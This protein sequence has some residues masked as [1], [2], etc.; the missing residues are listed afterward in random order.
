M[1]G[2]LSFVEL[3]ELPCPAA[4]VTMLRS[5]ITCYQVRTIIKV[6]FSIAQAGDRH[7]T[8][9]LPFFCSGHQWCRGRQENHLLSVLQHAR[10]AV[11]ASSDV[12]QNLFCE[13]PKNELTGLT[14]V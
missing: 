12:L 7:R 1:N 9:I 8:T 13:I 2:L 11:S 6:G 10:R 3:C 14:I 5:L 4:L